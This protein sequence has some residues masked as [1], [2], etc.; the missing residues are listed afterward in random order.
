[1]HQVATEVPRQF[2]LQQTLL[3]EQH[4]PAQ[5]AGEPGTGPGDQFQPVGIGLSK[6][7]LGHGNLLRQSPKM[8]HCFQ[9]GDSLHDPD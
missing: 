1:M 6:C 5:G 8:L 9:L 4:Q 2:V 7:F 3:F